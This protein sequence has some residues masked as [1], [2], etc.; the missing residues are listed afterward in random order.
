MKTI[1]ENGTFRKRSPEWNFFKTL[2]SRVRVQLKTELFR[3]YQ[4]QS[5][6]RVHDSEHVCVK[7]T[8]QDT[9]TIDLN[10]SKIIYEKPLYFS[11]AKATVTVIWASPFPKP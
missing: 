9:V 6:L 4:F 10:L 5:I 11:L 7:H 1:N 2:F 3:H 8:I